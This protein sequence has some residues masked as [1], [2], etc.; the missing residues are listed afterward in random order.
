MRED[1]RKS[2]DLKSLKLVACF[3]INSGFVNIR[4]G[5]KGDGYDIAAV[6][7]SN[8]VY[9]FN[10]KQRNFHSGKYGDLTMDENDFNSLQW[11]KEKLEG[12]GINA[13]GVYIQ[14][15][16]DNVMF[17]ANDEDWGILLKNCPTTTRFGNNDYIQKRLKQKMQD[18]D[19]V[20]RINL[21]NVSLDKM[22]IIY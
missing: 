1:H 19:G 8:D 10:V 13:K 9:L 21:N 20:K 2:G 17:I 4:Y 16:A 5:F 14:F 18:A 15:F 12:E 6:S 3:L 22:K 7:E 11:V